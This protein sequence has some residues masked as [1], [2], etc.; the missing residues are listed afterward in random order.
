MSAD[1][2]RLRV[3]SI[4]DVAAEYA[5]GQVFRAMNELEITTGVLVLLAILSPGCTSPGPVAR[6]AWKPTPTRVIY[7]GDPEG[8][9]YKVQPCVVRTRDGTL[10]AMIEP[11]EEPIFIRST[12]GGETWCE[13]YGGVLPDKVGGIHTLGVRRDGRLIAAVGRAEE[14]LRTP[15]VKKSSLTLDGGREC[16][17]YTGYRYAQTMRLVSSSD[18]GKT[19]TIGNKVDLSPLV[20]G[21][22]WVGGKILELDDG[23]LLVPVGCYLSAEEMDGIWLSAGVL[24]TNDEGATWSASVIARANRDACG[25]YSEPAIAELDDGTLVALLRTGDRVTSGRSSDEPKWGGLHRSISSD[26]GK[27]WTTFGQVLEGSH[28]SVVQLPD[29]VILCGFHRPPQLALSTDKGE[30]W[31]ES[32]L[33]LTDEPTKN[34]GWY[35]SVEVVDDDTAIALMKAFPEPHIIYSCLLHRQ[36]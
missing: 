14:N 28:C 17:V 5:C 10:V 4:L 24:R 23:T 18:H 36:R 16:V 11:G 12:D 2:L 21:W 3:L 8:S 6:S 32:M 25:Y 7:R 26:R 19:W 1:R 13:P 30:T 35:T 22:T 15:E 33:W 9:R 31:Y 29:R 34:W 27:T 20:S